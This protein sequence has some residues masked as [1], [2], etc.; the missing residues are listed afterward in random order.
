MMKFMLEERNV[1]RRVFDKQMNERIKEYEE[2]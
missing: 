2:S 1:Q